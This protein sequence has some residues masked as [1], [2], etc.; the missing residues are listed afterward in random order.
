MNVGL[1]Q[2]KFVGYLIECRFFG[3]SPL[4][5]TELRMNVLSLVVVGGKW[6]RLIQYNSVSMI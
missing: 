4:G 2:L 5:I 1:S 6:V 3:E